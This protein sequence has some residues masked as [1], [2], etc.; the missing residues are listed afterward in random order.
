MELGLL[1]KKGSGG[2]RGVK[3]KNTDVITKDGVSPSVI[4]R[5]VVMDKLGSLVN[6][7]FPTA[8][9]MELCSYPPLPTQGSN[10]AGN[11]PG[12]SS[13][14]NITGNTPEESTRAIIK[15][16]VNTA[17]GFFLG[18][19]VAYPVVANYVRNTWG[20]YGLVKSI[21]NSSTGLFQFSSMDG[22]N[23]MLEYGPWFI[24]SHPLI[25]KKL[26]P[27]ENLIKEDIRDVSV[28]VKLHDVP[29][30]A[31]SEDGS[32]AIAM[33]IGTSLMLDSYNSD[34]CLRS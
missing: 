28:W 10:P 32:S 9:N 18:K 4:V 12:M 3:E 24:R 27:S 30:T 29:I 16:F 1:S 14:A 2:R 11:T 23:A 15:R 17:Y 6:T 8:D 22:L 7:S 5:T 13:Y 34:M 19:R 20:K 33:K 26:N 31:F 25:L 21:L